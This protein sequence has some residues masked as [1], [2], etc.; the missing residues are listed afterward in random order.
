MVGLVRRRPLRRLIQAIG[1]AAIAVLATAPTAT[2]ELEQLLVD[3]QSRYFLLE[4][5]PE[6]RP[7]PTIIMLHGGGSFP[8]RES[9]LSGLGQ[10]ATQQGFVAV[11]PEG[12]ASRWNVLPPGVA[13]ER[14]AQQF[15][16][17]GGPPDDIGFLR[18]LSAELVRRGIADPKRLYL[19]GQSAGGFM[20]LRMACLGDR[21]FAATGLLITSMLEAIGANCRPPSPLPVL[22]LGG[23]A[24]NVVP[25]YGGELVLPGVGPRTTI[26]V[27]PA[28][29]TAEF[30]RQHNGCIG[31]PE[32]SVLPGQPHRVE[33]ERSQCP[34]GAVH[35]YRLVGAG[36]NPRPASPNVSQLLI[37]FFRDKI[38]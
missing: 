25:Y 38:R 26:G 2:A 29:R 15:Q 35:S 5:P 36:H 32:T 31:R 18:A 33:V 7:R 19:A 11:F 34:G 28:E 3:G 13:T 21:T 16:A 20:T 14:V 37:D 9:L 30:F 10:R 4:R 1:L 6:P 27:W 23:T 22:M 8:A 12:R 17:Y 24:D